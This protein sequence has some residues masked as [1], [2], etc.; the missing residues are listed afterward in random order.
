MLRLWKRSGGLWDGV[1]APPVAADVITR[2]L[3]RGD[4]TETPADNNSFAELL[5]KSL[6]NL[7]IPLMFLL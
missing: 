1:S 4:K 2:D 7:R 5:P 6:I 3:N